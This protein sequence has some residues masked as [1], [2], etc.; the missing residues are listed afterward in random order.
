[1][2]TRAAG[3]AATLRLR[4]GQQITESNGKELHICA[5]AAGPYSMTHPGQ[6]QTH[7]HTHTHTHTPHSLTHS[8]SH[9]L[10]ASASASLSLSLSLSLA[11]SRAR[12]L[13]LS[14]SLS[15]SLS[16]PLPLSPSPA[17]TTL[18]PTI[19]H[20]RRAAVGVELV[21]RGTH[22]S[23]NRKQVR[24]AALRSLA[25]PWGACEGVS[26]ISTHF[27][28]NICC[29]LEF[30]ASLLLPLSLC[31]SVTRCRQVLLTVTSRYQYVHITLF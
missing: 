5:R 6:T 23:P 12:A 17:L 30:G 11:R 10:S 31:L 21:E 19:A 13:S 9:S 24:R 27:V 15:P 4:L 1:V 8:P 25:C 2:R 16:L 29:L 26:N 28:L 20:S 14:L 3:A 22:A 18:T 7:R